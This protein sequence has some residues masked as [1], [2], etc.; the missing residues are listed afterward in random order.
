MRSGITLD[1]VTPHLAMRRKVA[2]GGLTLLTVIILMITYVWVGIDPFKLY[3]KRQ[4]AMS[5]LFGRQMTEDDKA[6]AMAQARRL[7]KIILLEETLQAI[8]QEYA[9]QGKAQ[10]AAQ[11]HREASERV[12][13][14]LATQSPEALERIVQEEYA[15]IIDEK[16]G[17][18]FPPERHPNH[19]RKYFMALLETVAIAIWGSLFAVLAAVPV[20]VLAATNTLEIVCQGDSRMHRAIRWF[21]YFV[22]RRFLDF[23]R[24]FNEFVMAL[25]FVAVIGLGPFAGVLALAIHTFGVGK[26]FSEA[27][28]SIRDRWKPSWPAVPVPFGRFFGIAAGH[29]P[30]G[31]LQSAA[32]RIQ[33]AQRDHPG[34]LRGGWHRVSD[35]RQAQWLSLPR[36]GHH[37]DHG[38]HQCQHYRLLVRKTAQSVHLTA[39]Q[40]DFWWSTYAS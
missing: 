8:K 12:A 1:N 4:N 15:R 13:G 6:A 24:G 26:V 35:V 31:Q 11:M 16:K 34:V 7:P 2:L 40:S 5:Y 29:A 27:K 14:K 25:I 30:D 3:D 19:L 21:S 38:D 20:S 22:I 17:G 18:F 37:D 28:P 36:G 9:Q 33:C 10:D 39:S 23:C 32:L